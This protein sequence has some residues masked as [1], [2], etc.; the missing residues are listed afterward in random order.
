MAFLAAE[1]IFDQRE[2]RDRVGGAIG[3]GGART[4]YLAF[5]IFNIFLNS[6]KVGVGLIRWIMR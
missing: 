5:Y 6:S 4:A 2:V 1:E 3:I